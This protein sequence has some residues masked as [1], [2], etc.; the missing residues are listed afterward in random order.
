[1]IQ[2]N[3]D[4]TR[5]LLVLLIGFVLYAS[6]PFGLPSL[7]G[8]TKGEAIPCDKAIELAVTARVKEKGGDLI[9]L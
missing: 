2:L 3:W 7:A 6:F 9:P 5:C 1:M 8:G 4:R